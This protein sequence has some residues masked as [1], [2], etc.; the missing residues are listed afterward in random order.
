MIKIEDLKI[1]LTVS[2]EPRTF[3]KAKTGII[4]R[5]RRIRETV[6]LYKILNILENNL[7]EVTP[8][9][10]CEA[11]IKRYKFDIKNL[12]IHND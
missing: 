3:G 11:G 12:T 5:G 10:G 6:K 7:V 2:N 4:S 1:G 8:K 9:S